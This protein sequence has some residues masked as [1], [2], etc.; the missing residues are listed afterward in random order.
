MEWGYDNMLNNIRRTDAKR[1]KKRRSRR[2]PKEG[3]GGNRSKEKKK[4]QEVYPL[5]KKA[6]IWAGCG[7]KRAREHI[8]RGYKIKR[9]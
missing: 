1:M 9:H 3:S 4:L 8:T 5:D 6:G 7:H 2:T